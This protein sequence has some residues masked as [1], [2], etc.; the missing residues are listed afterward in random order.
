MKNFLDLLSDA[1]PMILDV[2]SV[3]RIYIITGRTDFRKGMLSLAAMVRD[4]YDLDPFSDAVFI[5]S[6]RTRKSVKVLHWCINGFELY[7][8]T[9]T[10]K[11]KYQWPNDENEAMLITK[12]QLSWLLDGLSIHQSKAFHEMKQRIF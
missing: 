1:Y 7:T 2:S 11:S 5:F 3:K 4:I 12:K 10:D 9:V 8:K 6:N